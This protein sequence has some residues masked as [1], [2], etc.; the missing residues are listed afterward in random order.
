MRV[1]V[2]RA[3]FS[4]KKPSIGERSMPFM[5]GMTPRKM[6]RNG[7][8]T[9]FSRRKGSLFQLMLLNHVRST[10]T[11]R[12]RRYTSNVFAIAAYISFAPPAET[13]YVE[14]AR[15][16]DDIREGLS[17]VLGDRHRG[18]AESIFKIL[19]IGDGSEACPSPDPWDETEGL[20]EERL[21][22]PTVLG[23]T[24]ACFHG[25]LWRCKEGE[26]SLEEAC[27]IMVEDND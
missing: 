18:L 4:A 7:S 26:H 19:L 8:V 20:A 21:E 17:V 25:A 27:S 2:D 24:L 9:C 16:S 11:I 6:L 22:S 5:G 23:V 14:T 13:A 3:K 10:R 1:K 12:M 15:G